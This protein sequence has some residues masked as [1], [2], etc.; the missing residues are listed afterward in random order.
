MFVLVLATGTVGFSLSAM[1][2]TPCADSRRRRGPVRRRRSRAEFD[3][4]AAVVFGVVA[5]AGAFV[6]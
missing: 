1:L 2:G 6:V 5:V 4:W 3:G